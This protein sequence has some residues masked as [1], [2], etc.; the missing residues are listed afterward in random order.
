MVTFRKS[1]GVAAALAL[2]LSLSACSSSSDTAAETP[3]VSAPAASAPASPT[4]SVGTANEA[5]CTST[6]A[7]KA[8]LGNLQ[9]LVKGGSVTV[10]AL[11]SQ[12]DALKAA[13]EQ[14]KTDGQALDA[15]V[16]AEVTA[17]QAAFQ[18]AIDAIPADQT[19][20]KEVAAY[21]AA[22]VVFAKALDAIDNEVGCA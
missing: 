11:Q 17:A 4:S 18:T 15:A 13:G 3:A 5:F 6:A 8:E 1:A 14:A 22:A 16:Q 12:R 20:L 10:E 7:L 19:G 21:T 9:T 2:A